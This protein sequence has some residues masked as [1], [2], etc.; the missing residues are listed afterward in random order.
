[1]SRKKFFWTDSLDSLV[2]RAYQTARNRQQLVRNITLLEQTT[3]FSRFAI[4][5]RAAHLGVA[6]TKPPSW[7]R[8]EIEH[9]R[10]LLGTAGRRTIAR[11]LGRSE[12][13]VKAQLRKLKLSLEFRD[14]YSGETLASV[15]GTSPKT[16][17]RW[18]QMRWLKR[19]DNRFSESTIRRFLI[20]HPEQYHLGR[21]D[22]AW[23]KGMVFE[24]Y[25]HAETHLQETRF[26][27]TCETA[28]IRIY[29]EL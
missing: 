7:T 13:S 10:E 11:R 26:R 5:Q 20:N 17:R 23:F 14:G 16:V 19:V 4:R 25:N 18:E 3:S 15:L 1:M 29:G 2:R 28:E 9:L 8:E 27:P 24:R 12:Y 6:T 21:V 22:E